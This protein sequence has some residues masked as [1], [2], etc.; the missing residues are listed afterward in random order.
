[1]AGYWFCKHGEKEL[2]PYS[3]KQLQMFVQAGKLKPDALLRTD[4]SREWQPA[5][6]VD[7]LFP[8]F[9]APDQPAPPPV[10]AAPRVVSATPA[11]A[12]PVKT[13][14]S[15]PR[16]KPLQAAAL[17]A[18]ATHDTAEHYHE[19][20]T[21]SEPR[22]LPK[23]RPIQAAAAVSPAA[24]PAAVPSSPAAKALPPAAGP[25][26]AATPIVTPSPASSPFVIQTGSPI[27]AAP[28]AASPLRPAPAGSES[29][30]SF[31]LAVGSLIVGGLGLV[32]FAFPY[33]AIGLGALGALLATGCFMIP[34]AGN[35]PYMAIG[36]VVLGVLAGGM[37]GFL[38]NRG[39]NQPAVPVAEAPKTEDTKKPAVELSEEELDKQAK[40]KAEV[41][42]KKN[43]TTTVSSEKK[44]ET[45]NAPGVESVAAVPATVAKVGPFLATDP[46][47]KVVAATRRYGK[48]P[49]SLTLGGEKRVKVSRV[50][51][52]DTPSDSPPASSAPARAPGAEPMPMPAEEAAEPKPA[53]KP[54]EDDIPPLDITGELEK[55]PAKPKP[56][57][58]K[59]VEPKPMPKEPTI[60]LG[61]SAVKPGKY[62]CVEVNLANV[63]KDKP[64][65]VAVLSAIPGDLP[66]APILFDN[67]QE[68][69]TA[70]PASGAVKE[71]TARDINPGEEVTEVLIFETPA[72]GF[73]FVRFV[74]PSTTVSASQ[75]FGFE[76]PA[77]AFAGGAAAPA[78]IPSAAPVL[79]VP[80]KKP[81]AAGELPP[82][83]GE[84][85][86]PEEGDMP[87]P[88]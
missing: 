53:K 10:A 76:I 26:V 49:T 28:A 37:G 20:P 3:L 69:A 77:A 44:P 24:K 51:Y 29:D 50:W 78:A 71:A 63:G 23:G 74:I 73:E 18:A 33:G 52:S 43:E 81:P 54:A 72:E 25:V 31:Q 36:G 12:A 75:N 58:P 21:V 87:K 80:M 84:D 4:Q 27:A 64:W 9:G 17:P 56:I 60:V 6:S 19:A 1:M 42:Q 5:V 48:Y 14:T 38:V 67:R 47:A 7:G 13:S 61:E 59:P 45:K 65:K 57:A 55:G 40:A 68:P 34:M 35:T 88:K 83:P 62:M 30:R 2:G 8:D 46:R 41:E 70:V 39:Q 79:K 86:T 22:S 82:L 16:G 32:C 11:P 15:L 66:T 85:G